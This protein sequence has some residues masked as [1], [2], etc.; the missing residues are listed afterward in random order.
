MRDCNVIFSSPQQNTSQP[1]EFEILWPHGFFSENNRAF[2]LLNLSR[3]NL[4]AQ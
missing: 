3:I 4:F 1:V 2:K